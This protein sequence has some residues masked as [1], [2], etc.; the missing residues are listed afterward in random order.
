MGFEL[1]YS[2]ETPNALVLW[3]AQFGDFVN[4]AQVIIDTFLCCGEQKWMRQSGLVLLLPHGYEGQGP[5]HSSARLERFLKLADENPT[6]VPDMDPSVRTQVQKANMQIVNITTP[7]NYFHALRRQIHRNFRKPLIVMSP[8][9]LLRHE[10]AVSTEDEFLNGKFLRLIGEAFPEE[11]SEPKKI[12]RL[13][14]CTG[15]VYYD[16]L[17]ERRAKK[18]TNSAIVRLEQIHPFPWD[19]VQEQANLYPKAKMIWCQEEP[20]NMGSWSFVYFFF[21]TA[22]PERGANILYAGRDPT[23]SPAT[24]SYK[25][26]VAQQDRLVTDALINL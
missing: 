18:L 7:A 5:E 21:K 22:V 3:E 10:W 19:K 15:K 14:F 17:K 25:L 23:T 26:H 13:I 8:K 12:D 1:G 6:F 20:M 4:G 2:F 9:S 16:L 24:G 11:I